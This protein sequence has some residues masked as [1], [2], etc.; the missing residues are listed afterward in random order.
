[1]PPVPGTIRIRDLRCCVRD[2]GRAPSA[3]NTIYAGTGSGFFRSTDGGTSWIKI[4]TT[5]VSSFNF[6][7]A[8][9]VDPFN[10]SVVYLGHFFG[11]FKT[12]DGGSN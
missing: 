3:P 1:M 10:P 2:R 11:L 8:L 7:G 4:T 9:V 6:A 5:G 12:T